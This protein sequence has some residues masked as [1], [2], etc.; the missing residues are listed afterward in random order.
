[1]IPDPVVVA[2]DLTRR[3]RDLVAVDGVSFA[4]DRGECCGF[5]GPNGAGKTST[6]KIMVL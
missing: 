3:Y 1:M 2:R 5:L 6:V 4:I